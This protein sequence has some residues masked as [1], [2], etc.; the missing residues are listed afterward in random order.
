VTTIIGGELEA[1]QAR[2][3]GLLKNHAQAQL[4]RIGWDRERLAA[5]QRNGLRVLLAHARRA[6]PFY[7]RRLRGIEIEQ[8][9]P[10]DLARLP[11]MRKEHVMVEFDQLVTDRRLT[12]RLAEQTLAASAQEPRLLFDRYVCLASGQ[13]GVARA[14]RADP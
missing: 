7:A 1:L 8:F 5:H 12:R 13:L 14:V 4:P 11:V 9:E 6:S 3:A 2:F 10:E